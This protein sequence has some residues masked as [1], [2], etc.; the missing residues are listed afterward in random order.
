MKFGKEKKN[1]SIALFPGM[2]L[3]GIVSPMA[4]FIARTK[5]FACHALLKKRK[6][7]LIW[8]QL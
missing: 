8:I 2:T 7:K 1:T 4:L 6:R 3:I 5:S